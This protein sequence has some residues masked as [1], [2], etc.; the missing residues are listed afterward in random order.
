[1]TDRVNSCEPLCIELFL[2]CAVAQMMSPHEWRLG[3][4][5]RGSMYD[6]ESSGKYRPTAVAH[7]WRLI[8]LCCENDF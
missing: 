7:D 6:V 5:S 2:I 8:L 4:C 1:M 3:R